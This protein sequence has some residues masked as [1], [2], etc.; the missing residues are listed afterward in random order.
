MLDP[1]NDAA[2]LDL[3]AALDA[4]GYDFVTTTPETHARVI[5]RSASGTNL[6]DLFGWSRVVPPAA[7][8][9]ALRATIERA[10]IVEAVA[11]GWRSRIRVTRLRGRLFVHSAFPTD[12]ANSVFFGPDSYR[13]ADFIIEELARD[14]VCRNV[15]DIGT[16]SGVGVIVASGP[17][18]P[19]KFAMTDINADALACARINAAHAGLHVEALLGEGL[20]G[21]VG[22]VDLALA[23]PPYLI[24][25]DERA[26]RHG[27][28]MLG[29]QLSLDMAT[30]IAARLS[31]GGRLLLYTGSAIVAGVDGFKAALRGAAADAG[32]TLRYRELDPDVFGEELDRPAYAE[33]KVERIAAVGAVLTRR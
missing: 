6:R 4:G 7:L 3:L 1:R 14:S 18:S 24:D 25:E 26:Y 20:A 16:G 33:A 5:A 9:P 13:F 23:N 19:A 2:L 22:E 21:F 15:V 29:G 10:G 32:C 27:G 17:A 12:D 8:D 31:P 11:G 30:E 28:G